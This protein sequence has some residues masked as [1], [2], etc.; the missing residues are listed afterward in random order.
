MVHSWAQNV[1][2]GS[3]FDVSIE[4]IAPNEP[5]LYRSEWMFHIA[6]GPLLGVGADR[7]TPLA[8]HILVGTEDTP[9]PGDSVRCALPVRESLGCT[10]AR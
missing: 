4:M 7:L 8:A 9:S 10:H 3:T 2:P 5:G 6:D 1:P